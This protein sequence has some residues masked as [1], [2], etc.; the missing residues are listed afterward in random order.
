MIQA[1]PELADI[2]ETTQGSR[3]SQVNDG[4][5]NIFGI[6]KIPRF[7]NME[8]GDTTWGAKDV[9]MWFGENVLKSG[10]N[11]VSDVGNVLL[12]PVDSAVNI[13]KLWVGAWVNAYE[14]VT[15]DTVDSEYG[16]MASQAGEYIK[17]RFG[18]AEWFQKAAYEDPVGLFSDIASLI[19]WGAWLAGKATAKAWQLGKISSLTKAGDVLWDVAKAADIIDPGNILMWKGMQ[20]YG[21]WFDLWKTAVWRVGRAISD[22]WVG[23]KIQAW[24]DFVSQ[25]LIDSK[26]KFTKTNKDAIRKASG[27]DP[28]KLI[29]ENDLTADNVDGMVEKTQKMVDNAMSQKFKALEQVKDPQK[30]TQRD[31]LIWQSIVNQ[32]K[33]D[34]SE[35]YGKAFDD[36]TQDE[37]IPELKDQ[38]EIIKNI[39]ETL[40]SNETS[41]LKLEAMKSLYD[42][43][44]SHL[45]YDPTKKRILS[46]AEK[47][48]LWLQSDIEKLGESV[49]VDI[50]QLN[51]KIAWGKAL[52]KWLIQAGDRM[53]NNNIFWLSDSQ[54]AIL[55]SVLGWG[56][57][58]VAS[59][60]WAKS[61]FENMW[62]RNKIAKSLYWKTTNDWQK[63]IDSNTSAGTT[64]RS[65]ISKQF[66]GGDT[67]VNGSKSDVQVKKSK[68]A[69]Q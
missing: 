3:F 46:S 50:K 41:A 54:T 61:L 15:G 62:V 24:K 35:V 32:A 27:M 60:L 52:E 5:T 47:I 48:R 20:A 59:V 37:I 65:N 7:N 25:K 68:K 16:D 8:S 21:K 6:P 13:G 55:W 51:K 38:F 66:G 42:M 63:L 23:E 4:E 17:S 34:I 58:E 64:A 31:K 40:K 30:I 67:T 9:L 57:L 69:N 33:N 49:G 10:A 1:Y 18:S 19:S 22:T 36:I 14:T 39:Q 44:N 12:D 28:A 11:L 2:Q 56:G 53:D 29:L 45:K 26:F 43:Y